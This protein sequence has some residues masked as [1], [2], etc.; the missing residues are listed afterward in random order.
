LEFEVCVSTI[1]IAT[2]SVGSITSCRMASRGSS[3]LSMRSFGVGMICAAAHGV[4]L[5]ASFLVA[6]LGSSAL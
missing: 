5:P 2:L 1:G 3:T 4:G 6:F